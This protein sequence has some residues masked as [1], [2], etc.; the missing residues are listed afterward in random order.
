MAVN[1][2]N[3]AE[4]TA[5]VRAGALAGITEFIGMVEKRAVE[6]I[7]SPPKTGRIYRRRGVVHQAS[8]GGEAP[9]SDTGRLVNSRRVEIIESEIR[10]RLTFSTAYALPLEKGTVK[11]EPRPYAVRALNETRQA[12]IDIVVQRVREAVK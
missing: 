3:A 5:A 9:A 2:W 8:A 7:T 4:L 10:G 1:A 6:L 11:M 12:G